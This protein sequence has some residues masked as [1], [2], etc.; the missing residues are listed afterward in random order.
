MSRNKTR[1]NM[2]KSWIAPFSF[3]KRGQLGE[4]QL[5]A[6]KLELYLKTLLGC[7]FKLSLY[8]IGFIQSSNL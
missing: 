4:K 6:V 5:K 8:I 2:V 1:F 3:L 7:M